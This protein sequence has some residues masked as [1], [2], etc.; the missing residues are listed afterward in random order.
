MG[1]RV[2]PMQRSDDSQSRKRV[3]VV[4]GGGVSGLAALRIFLDR[5]QLKGPNP[6]WEIDAFETRHDVG[7]VWYPEIDG[8]TRT[9]PGHDD[10]VPPT[11]L[12]HSLTTNI[13]HPLM[14]FH[15]FQFPPETPLYPHASAVHRYLQDY[16]KHYDLRKYISF[17]SSVT[18]AR[19]DSNS[20]KWVLDVQTE[21]KPDGSEFSTS[22]HHY[23]ALIVANG[24]YGLPFT[25]S[26]PGFDEWDASERKIMHSIWYREPSIFQDLTILVV[27]GGPSGNDLAKDALPVAR[28]VIHATTSGK[29]MDPD[30]SGVYTRA[31]LVELR[32]AEGGTVV[33]GDGTSDSG[34]DFV[35]LATGYVLTFPFLR[36]VPQGV[37]L[38]PTKDSEPVIPD[39]LEVTRA[40]IVPLTRHTF[41]LRTYSPKTLAFVGL[42][43]ALAPFPAADIQAEAIATVFFTDSE[44]GPKASRFLR[45]TWTTPTSMSQNPFQLWDQAHEESLFLSRY[46]L[47]S[48]RF[49]GEPTSIASNLHKMLHY[50]PGL[51]DWDTYRASLLELA[52]STPPATSSSSAQ[53]S[54]GN[55]PRTNADPQRKTWSA[56]QW[57]RDIYDAKVDM[58]TEWQTLEKEGESE[59]WLRGVGKGKNAQKEW[60]D[61]M[62]RVMQH[63]EERKAGSQQQENG[64][65]VDWMAL[66]ERAWDE[67]DTRNPH[68]STGGFDEEEGSI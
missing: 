20:S 55:K 21:T 29:R 66:L 42:P 13:P 2:E 46:S 36:D 7:G 38:P 6:T 23:D 58:R 12:Y 65:T 44:D 34:I 14:A 60:A 15:D 1:Q 11:P 47:L 49:H 64:K 24:H 5:P 45:C 37:R 3:A 54:S 52:L 17:G 41:P 61:L 59:K 48:Q 43:S 4:G 56:K 16:A 30:G 8:E 18:S 28:R 31:R 53:S 19:W 9:F 68:V 25:P 32:A 10:P 40:S 39:E 51:D 63:A 62:Y 50:T 57:E 27:G 33:Y 26:I 67:I 35:I 22:T